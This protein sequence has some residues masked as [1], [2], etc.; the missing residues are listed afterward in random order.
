MVWQ[1]QW[2]K[3]KTAK[4]R[5]KLETGTDKAKVVRNKGWYCIDILSDEYLTN[6]Y[7]KLS[8]TVEKNDCD[9]H[10]DLFKVKY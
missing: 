5:S 8:F 10:C 3:S 6:A 1:R 2:L 7:K 9:L 4:N